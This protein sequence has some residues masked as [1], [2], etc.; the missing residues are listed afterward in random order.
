MPDAS[1]SIEFRLS[2]EDATARLGALLARAAL[3]GDW[4]LLEGPLGAGKTHLA[5]AFIRE[6]LAMADEPPEEVP[7]PSYTLVQGYRAGGTEIIHAD[8]YR[9]TGP[10]EVAELGLDPDDATAL[11]L[12]EWPDRLGAHRPGGALWVSLDMDGAG[13]RVRLTVPAARARLIEG[14]RAELAASE[15]SM[16]A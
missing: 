3:P 5:R 2:D 11:T 10:D 4:L 16:R 9:L 12:V 13:R 15:G 7:S 1:R 8:L 14:L 6:R